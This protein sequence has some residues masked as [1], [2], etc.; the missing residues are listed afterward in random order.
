MSAGAAQRRART[1]QRERFVRKRSES[2]ARE[3]W[4]ALVANKTEPDWQRFTT[5]LTGIRMP[6]CGCVK[7]AADAMTEQAH[8]DI[9]GAPRSGAGRAKKL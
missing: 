3:L 5:H 8:V 2:A 1:Q 7:C 9:M 6:T 4:A